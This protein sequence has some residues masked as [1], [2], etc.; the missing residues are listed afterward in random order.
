M[1]D[2]YTI[3]WT[4]F[5]IIIVI[6]ALVLIFYKRT[7]WGNN[8]IRTY[9]PWL[10]KYIV[11]LQIII[12]VI[13]F[14]LVHPVTHGIIIAT[15]ALLYVFIIKSKKGDTKNIILNN[16]DSSS[17]NIINILCKPNGEDSVR[18]AR[19]KLSKCIFSAPYIVISSSP[20]IEFDGIEYRVSL[21]LSSNNYLSS[22]RQYLTKAGFQVIYI[23][24]KN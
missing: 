14:E 2:L 12:S 20:N 18:E 15:L 4:T 23:K 21:E 19:N 22:L 7:N 1:I 5:W 13:A 17:L 8:L 10:P 9:T 11:P 24:D 3:S 6:E 16:N